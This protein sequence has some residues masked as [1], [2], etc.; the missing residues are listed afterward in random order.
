MPDEAKTDRDDG[1]AEHAACRGVQDVRGEHDGKDRHQGERQGAHADEHK[2]D[3]GETTFRARRV[4]QGSARYLSDERDEPADRQHEADVY[5]GP[6]IGREIDGDERA[7]AR[8]HI[9]NEEGEPIEPA[10]ALA[11]GAGRSLGSAA[12]CATSGAL[13]SRPSRRSE[14]EARMR[15]DVWYRITSRA[16]RVRLSGP[17]FLGPAA[18]F[19]APVS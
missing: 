16:P 3:R 5:L 10:Q 1:G 12:R 8:L 11:R 7:K 9:G 14:D 15:L 13:P 4:H 2:R 18:R 6:F 19:S 17:H